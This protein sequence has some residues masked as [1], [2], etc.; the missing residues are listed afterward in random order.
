[1]KKKQKKADIGILG[2]VV[3]Y[4]LIHRSGLDLK[5]LKSKPLLSDY[6]FKRNCS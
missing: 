1:M 6:V 3:F 4:K 2:K 5:H